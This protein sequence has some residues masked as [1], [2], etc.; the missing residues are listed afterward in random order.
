MADEL[1][2]AWGDVGQQFGSLGRA[3]REHYQTGDATDEADATAVKDALKRLSDAVG[4]LADRTG[5]VVH[6]EGIRTHTRDVA[7]ALERALG[8]TVD[9]IG[10]SIDELVQRRK[11]SG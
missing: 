10:S 1:K 11:K 8:S 7:K 5:D 3:L 9:E 6:D 2:Q 4:D